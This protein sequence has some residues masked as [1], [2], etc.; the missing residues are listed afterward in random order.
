MQTEE[1]LDNM[2]IL[3]AESS[4]DLQSMSIDQLREHCKSTEFLER[5]NF[6]KR[7]ADSLPS[8]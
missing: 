8:K 7:S 2:N 4:A 3:E 1:V 5:R 6:R